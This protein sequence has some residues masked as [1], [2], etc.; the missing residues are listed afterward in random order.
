[1]FIG[2]VITL[3]AST[4]FGYHPLWYHPFAGEIVSLFCPSTKTRSALSH[5]VVTDLGRAS[6]PVEFRAQSVFLNVHD[7]VRIGT[8]AKVS[9]RDREFH[10]CAPC[11]LA[12]TLRRSR[13]ADAAETHASEHPVADDDG[14]RVAALL[15]RSHRLLLARRA[16][17][18][19]VR[20]ARCR[21]RSSW[22]RGRFT[23]WA[24]NSTHKKNTILTSVF[25]SLQ[26]G[27]QDVCD[28]ARDALLSGVSA[29][30]DHRRVSTTLDE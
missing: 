18:S 23:R 16:R 10:T 2:P 11:S 26:R 17:R 19:S 21:R 24:C 27:L 28:G 12:S 14:S 20:F 1:M 22:R 3:W 8:F 25:S 6:R 4:Q 5:S 9:L 15:R 29:D 7:V 13:Y 30:D